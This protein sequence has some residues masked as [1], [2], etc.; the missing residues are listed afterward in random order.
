MAG[1][2]ALL[3]RIRRICLALPDTKETPTW[4]KPHFRVGEKI[5]A[6]FG[7]E[8]G[9]PTLGMKLVAGHAKLVVRDPRFR[10]A[11]YVGHKGWVSM[12]VSGVDD[13][14]EVA[15][16]VLESYRLIAP[17][18]SL[19]RL[20]DGAP[21]KPKSKV[22]KTNTAKKPATRATRAKRA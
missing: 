11:P 18:R 7:E 16:L 1:M 21:A 8:D 14:D 4:S 22:A 12:D 10:P 13:W 3:N 2:T 15:E 5:F 17:K 6:G 9:R 20:V 19:A